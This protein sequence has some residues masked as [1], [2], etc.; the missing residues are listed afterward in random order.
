MTSIL[1]RR[2]LAAWTESND[3]VSLP[4]ING[5]LERKNLPKWECFVRLSASPHI[6]TSGRQVTRFKIIS[7]LLKELGN[8]FSV[9]WHSFD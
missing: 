5:E 1:V 9:N 4:T 8:I 6:V 2:N 7:R 3:L